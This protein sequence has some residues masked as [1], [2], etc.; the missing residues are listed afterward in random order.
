[1]NNIQAVKIG[2]MVNISLNG[3]LYKKN[4]GTPKEADELF[5]IVLKAK[6]NPDD[7]DAFKQVRIALNEKLRTALMCGIEAD[8]ETG[9]AYLAGFNTPIPETLLEVMKEYHENKYPLEPIINFWKLLMVNPDTR[10]RTTLFDFISTHDF[11]LTDKGYMLVYKAVYHKEKEQTEASQFEEFISKQY[12][13]IKKNWNCSPNKYVGYKEKESG[14]LKITKY[15]TAK[16]WDEKE[17]GIEI[18][19]KIGDLYEAIITKENAEENTNTV[20]RSR[21]RNS[22]NVR[23]TSNA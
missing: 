7:K 23:T 2:N 21:K 5:K 14:E 15:N 18:I 4:C 3:K 20:Y 22:T 1:M 10:I 13:H 6:E 16:N 19:G 17:K 12:L 11:V 8:V 9:E